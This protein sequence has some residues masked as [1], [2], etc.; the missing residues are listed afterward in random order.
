MS[1]KKYSAR[2]KTECAKAIK[3]TLAYRDFFKSQLTFYQICNFLVCAQ[4]HKFTFALLEEV[5]EELVKKGEVKKKNNRGTF[6]SLTKITESVWVK[7][8]KYS[9]NLIKRAEHIF[10]ILAVVPWLKMLAVTGSV[11]AYSAKRADDVDIFIIC[12]KKRVWITRFFVV[13]LLKVLN[14]YPGH[15][16]AGYICP[17]IYV[18]ESKMAWDK[19]KRNLYV[20]HEIA[21]MHPVV[22]RDNTYFRFMQENMWIKEYLGNFALEK[23]TIKQALLRHSPLIDLLEAVFRS[24]QRAYMKNKRTREIVEDVLIHFNKN[25]WTRQI[26]DNYEKTIKKL[27]ID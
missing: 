23:C 2:V 5:L 3:S 1:P 12:G 9:H 26:L 21:M 17:N 18:D 27:R 16:R 13:L 10:D 20:A 8:A 24:I 7:R 14:K 22:N 6:Y 19:S 4:N 15:D 11:A 25:D